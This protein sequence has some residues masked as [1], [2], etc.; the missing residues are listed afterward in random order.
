MENIMD[1]K[2][3]DKQCKISPNNSLRYYLEIT[4]S[5]YVDDLWQKSYEKA[6]H[7]DGIGFF[8]SFHANDAPVVNKI[9]FAGNKIITPD[10]PKIAKNDVPEF[11]HQLEKFI[12]LANKIYMSQQTHAQQK[13]ELEE[14]KQ[15]EQIK[16]LEEMNKDLNS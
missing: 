10:F 8:T 13:K 7:S 9:Q 16:K 12:A 11:I 2:I 3:V 1:I 6:L 4:L 15:Q 5:D 14:M